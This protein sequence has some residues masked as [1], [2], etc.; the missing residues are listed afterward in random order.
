MSNQFGEANRPAG[1]AMNYREFNNAS[2]TMMYEGIRHALA[3]DDALEGL[4][5]KPSFQ[6]RAT[7]EWKRHG[8]ELER[9]ML[10]RGMFVDIIDWSEA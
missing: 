1:G 5:E 10:N 7:P 4:G 9:E 2:L 3:S 8:G 6:I